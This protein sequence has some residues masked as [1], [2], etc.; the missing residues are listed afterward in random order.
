MDPSKLH[1]FD[2]GLYYEDTELKFYKPKNKNFVSC[3]LNENMQNID[4]N[5]FNIVKVKSLPT[6]MKMLNHTT[7]DL[8]K[9]DIEG[10]ECEVL[11]H[12]MENNIFPKY[13]S[14]DFDSARLVEKGELKVKKCLDQLKQKY[15]IIKDDNYDISFK[16]K[17]IN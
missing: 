14:V 11:G 9:I 2:F 17:S 12:I 4:V 16:L 13:L 7:I 10:V 3:S 15:E 1:F 5:D 8:L 6:I